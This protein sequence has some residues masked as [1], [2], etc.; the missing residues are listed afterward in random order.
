MKKQLLCYCIL[1]LAL[2]GFS[3]NAQL[4]ANLRQYLLNNQTENTNILLNKH[5]GQDY[6][7][8]IIEI[9]SG[10]D[11][12]QFS[13]LGVSVGTKIGNYRTVQIPVS[14]IKNF[15]QLNNIKAIQLDE[16]VSLKMDTARYITGVDSI[17]RG[18]DIPSIYSGK[19]VIVGI[20][21]I[22]F[23]YTHP[24]FYDTTGT[25]L[26]VKKIWE[27]KKSG[28]PPKGYNYG[29]EITD[30]SEML[31][32]GSDYSEFSH[33][34]HV[35]GIAGGS[36]FGSLNNQKYRGVAYE[37]DL[38]F[39]GINPNQSEK[40]GVGYS[41]ILDGISYIFNY[42]KEQNKPAVVNLSWGVSLGPNDGSSLFGKTC[43]LLTGEGRIL[44]IPAGNNGLEKIHIQKVFTS[45][46]TTVKSFIKFLSVSGIKRTWL[47]I[48]GEPNKQFCLEFSLMKD[49]LV[50]SKS[51]KI[52]LE[53]INKSSFLIGNKGDTCYY[54]ITTTA[55]DQNGKPHIFVD[56]TS[57]TNE[58][59]LLTLSSNSGIVNAWL[60]YEDEISAYHGEF[61]SYGNTW[62]VDGD[63]KYTLGELACTKSA[64]TVAAFIS[65]LNYTNIEGFPMS[66]GF[67]SKTGD[68]APFSSIGPAADGTN[69]P[70][71]TAPGMTIGSSVNSYDF[72][73][74]P[75]G[76]NYSSLV[77][78]YTSPK[79]K[80]DYY[81]AEMSGTSMSGPFVSGIAALLLQV[82][83]KLDPGRLKQILAETAIT[84]KFTTSTPDPTRW[85][86]GKVNAYAAI[87]KTIQTLGLS[88]ELQ[89]GVLLN[90]YP[91]PTNGKLYIDI[92]S[93]QSKILDVVLMDLNGKKLMEQNWNTGNESSLVLDLEG[94]QEAIY[95]V[96]IKSDTGIFTRRVIISTP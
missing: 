51:E 28:T 2:S 49:Q 56:L 12:T 69:K 3:Q 90:I 60:D 41:S 17:H 4:S 21:D 34:A 27:Q 20:I 45:S 71:I 92:E 87:K 7:G 25:R 47:D 9:N 50:L 61:K 55:S 91:N 15:V 14:Q 57:K 94:L 75:N 40:I 5:N 77:A 18:I 68:I 86:F 62:A 33:G 96:Q 84:D 38:V 85:G 32:I 24:T 44:V 39:V 43:D 81:Y 6:L 73:Y 22:G 35:A 67:S 89:E 42:A 36:G 37:S 80:R 59:L 66:L 58:L 23:D 48:W 83:P 31:S 16:P 11:E 13:K 79:N 70:D 53:N 78:K 26:R 54:T 95:L 30:T 19:N 72:S 93:N 76:M 74:K 46:D 1:L 64:V 8:A 29:N 63:S 88:G 82:N 52:C 10:F 65:K